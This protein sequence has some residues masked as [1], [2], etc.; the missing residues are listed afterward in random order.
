M[1]AELNDPIAYANQNGGRSNG[2]L[3]MSRD[4]YF[5]RDLPD[6]EVVERPRSAFDPDQEWC[7]RC[8]PG[9]S[10]VTGEQREAVL[11]A[12]ELGYYEVPRHANLADVAAELGISHQ[13][14]SERLRRA[15]GGLVSAFVGGGGD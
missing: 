8:T 11:T 14:L 1:S 6:A 7:N 4:C 2:K 12:L 15:H 9:P 10:P 5:I 3:H 13:A